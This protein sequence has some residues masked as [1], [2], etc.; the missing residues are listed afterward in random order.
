[1]ALVRWDPLHELEEMADRLERIV[2]RPVLRRTSDSGKETL[3]V[4]EWVPAVDIVETPTEYLIKAE[5]PGVKKEEVKVTVVNGVLR[6][7]G[8]RAQEKE[9]KSKKFHRVERT[10]GSFVRTFTVPDDVDEAKVLA[11][12]RDGMLTV[13]LLKTEKTQRKAIEVK[14]A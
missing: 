4:P 5:L 1:M 14:V 3:T 12:F 8:E 11:D 7:G 6:I 9:E 13:H 10:Y 2:G